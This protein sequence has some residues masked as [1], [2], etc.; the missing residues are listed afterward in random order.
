MLVLDI[1]GNCNGECYLDY[2]TTDKNEIF[3]L[4]VFVFVY[5][6][7]FVLVILYNIY[8]VIRTYKK[9]SSLRELSDEEIS[10]NVSYLRW[11]PVALCIIFL[12]VSIYRIIEIW[13]QE[14]VFWF[15]IIQIILDKSR[16]IWIIICFSLNNNIKRL[17]KSIFYSE[18]KNTELKQENSSRALGSITGGMNV[19]YMTRN[20]MNDSFASFNEDD[21]E[22]GKRGDLSMGSNQD[23]E[24]NDNDYKN[25]DHA[26]K[27]NLNNN[28][29]T[30]ISK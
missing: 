15:A 29:T 22:F 8:S 17:V 2:E 7:M 30:Q 21:F 9:I 12:P 6:I 16:G 4:E 1:E 18:N 3:N 27:Y 10:E 28:S 23:S 20:N 24:N 19:S 11:Y 26:M 5:F 13:K 25:Y 14:R